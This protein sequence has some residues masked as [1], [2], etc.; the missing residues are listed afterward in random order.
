MANDL[1]R[2]SGHVL[3]IERRSGSNDRGPWA[4]TSATVLVAGRETTA[5]TI[6]DKLLAPSIGDDVDYLVQLSP[7]RGDS[8]RIRAIADYPV[9]VSADV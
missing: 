1:A 2:I 9:H 5:I 8:L 3:H 6:D 7:G 4:F